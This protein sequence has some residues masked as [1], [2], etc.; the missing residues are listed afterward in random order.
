MEGIGDVSKTGNRVIC[1]NI[2]ILVPM[3]AAH[4]YKVVWIIFSYFGNQPYGIVFN[5]IPAD[6][7]P[8]FVPN[9]VDHIRY[10]LVS[11]GHFSKKGF[12]SLQ[13][14]VAVMVMPVYQ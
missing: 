5:R 3:G 6:V 4:H 1:S 14:Q 8:G 9:L 13:M 2:N 11:F 12:G 7:A 10:A